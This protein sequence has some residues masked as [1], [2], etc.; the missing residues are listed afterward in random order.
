MSDDYVTLTEAARRLGVSE[1]AIRR[2]V[3]RGALQTFSNPQ[4]LRTVLIRTADL[5]T[6]AVPQPVMPVSGERGGGDAMSA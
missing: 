2:R 3:L 4:D 6:Y 5:N 1:P